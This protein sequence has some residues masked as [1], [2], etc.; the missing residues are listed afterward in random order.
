MKAVNGTGMKR[1]AL[2]NDYSCFGKCSL[3]VSVPILS[4]FGV[5]AVALPTA[6]LSTHTGGFDGYVVRDFTAEMEAFAEH[7]KQLELQ[8][9]CIYTGFF[10]SVKQIEFAMRFIRSFSGLDTLVIVDPVLGDNG[11]LYGCFTPDF[12]PAMRALASMAHVITPNRTEAALLAGLPLSSEDTALL[13]ALKNPVTVITSIESGSHIGYLARVEDVDVLRI[14]KEKAELT[15]HG[16]GDVFTSALCGEMLSGADTRTAL[17]RAA[18][19]CDD[20]IHATQQ[21]QPAHWYGL[22]FEDEL[23][24]RSL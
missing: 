4:S 8:F 12:V 19:F 11:R 10:L 5:E 3:S 9:D 24:R 14:E 23:K 22:A 6:I 20:C 21:R 2:L 13:D 7:W 1:A 16:A 17:V 15:L 18:A